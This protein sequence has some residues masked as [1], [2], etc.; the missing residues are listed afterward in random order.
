LEKH[1]HKGKGSLA[2]Q[3]NRQLVEKL[4]PERGQKQMHRRR[5]GKAHGCPVGKGKSI[6]RTIRP[7]GRGGLGKFQ[8]RWEKEPAIKKLAS[9]SSP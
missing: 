9:T 3:L 2:D 8:S 6:G 4:A 1:A 5:L 7:K